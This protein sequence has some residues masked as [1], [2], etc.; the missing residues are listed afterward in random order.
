MRALCPGFSRPGAAVGVA[1][2][3]VL[4]ALAVLAWLPRDAVAQTGPCAAGLPSA[5]DALGHVIGVITAAAADR[6]ALARAGALGRAVFDLRMSRLAWAGPAELQADVALDAPD[7]D[8]LIE[9]LAV[10][11]WA[12]RCEQ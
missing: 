4:A 9:A 11:L 10:F 3:A 5:R 7:E 8:A 12:S 2:L 6:A 1:V